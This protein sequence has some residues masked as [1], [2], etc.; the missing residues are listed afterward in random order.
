LRSALTWRFAADVNVS[1]IERFFG[2]A[3]AKASAAYSTCGR[4]DA[5]R[6]QSTRASAN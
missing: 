3:V 6:Y 2:H 5:G 4:T 1:Q